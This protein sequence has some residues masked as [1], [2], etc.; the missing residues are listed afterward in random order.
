MDDFLP[1]P[2]DVYRRLGVVLATRARGKDD[3][4]PAASIW[5]DER[6]ATRA[7]AR[8]TRCM[9]GDLA[10]GALDCFSGRYRRSQLGRMVLLWQRRVKDQTTVTV[11]VY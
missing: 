2:E 3:E 7:P 5:R 1:S 6:A 8:T 9:V 4:V 10:G 11:Y